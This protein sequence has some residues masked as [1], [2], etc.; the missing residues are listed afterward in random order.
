MKT[1]A[2]RKIK[3]AVKKSTT[4]KQKKVIK[5]STTGKPKKSAS[6]S[7]AASIKKNKDAQWQ[8]YKSLEKKAKTALN[9][10]QADIKKKASPT[11]IIE[12]KNA[13]MLLLGECDYMTRQCMRAAGRKKSVKKKA[14]KRA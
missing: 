3:K 11:V 7:S 1:R 5:K 9:K 8:T 14:K 10:L 2:K 13:L 12:D 4:S 6:L